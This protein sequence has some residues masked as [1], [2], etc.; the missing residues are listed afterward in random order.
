MKTE[1]R[2]K[3]IYYKRAV[4]GDCPLTLQELLSESLKADGI[5]AKAKTRRELLNPDDQ[6]CR[7]INHHKEY[8]GMLFGQLIFFEPGKSQALITLDDDAAFYEIKTIT[9]DIVDNADKKKVDSSKAATK[10]KEFIDSMLYFGVFDSHVVLMQS[11]ALRARELEA[12]LAWFLGTC[13][14]VI[15]KNTSLI[16]QDKPAEETIRKIERSP[17]K[18]VHLGTPIETKMEQDNDGDATIANDGVESRKIKW[19]PQGMGVDVIRAALGHDWFNKLELEDSLDDANLQ[20]SLEISYLRKT[21]K[22]GQKL[23]DNIATSLR[24][25]DE[26]DVRIDLFGGGTITGNELKL[27]GPVSVKTING[28]VDESDL[29]H[30]MHTWLVEKVRS[31]EIVVDDLGADD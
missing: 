5:A 30:Q 2:R 14:S 28:L 24:H 4:I 26:A 6:S 22:H 3:T 20:V 1:T 17:V 12:H 29:Y 8:N 9:P 15:D 10:Q 25:A 23:L 13:A 31:N 7:L 18:S 11:S 16:L 19:I 27:S 21:T